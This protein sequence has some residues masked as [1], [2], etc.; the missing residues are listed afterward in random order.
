MIN[1]VNM[2]IAV[3]I[4]CYNE[5]LTVTKVVNDFKSNLPDADIY[6]YDNNS[7]DKTFELAKKAGAITRHESTQGKGSVVRSMFRD[8]DA[9]YYVL[10][11]GDDTYPAEEVHGLLELAINENVDMVIGDRLSNGTYSQENKRNFHGFGNNL[12]L[13]LVN[14]IF[15]SNVNDIMT[16][17]RVFSKKFVKNIPIQSQG[18]QIETEM[19]V[20]ALNYKF[21]VKEKQITYRDR[22]E[23][24]FS[25]L[26]TIK[27]GYRVLSILSSLFKHSKPVLFFG[28]IS[29]V[30]I[31]LSLIVGVPVILEFLSTH[32]ITLVPSAILAS[33]LAIVAFLF[34]IV[35][36][37]LDSMSYYNKL[38]FE[39]KVNQYILNESLKNKG[40]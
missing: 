4:P 11:D 15:K 26:N 27:D 19:T 8:I 30:F 21:K 3:L 13:F 29:F 36:L 25:K 23:G 5:E 38:D 6:V 22:P 12:V 2:K 1:E 10:V 9:D 18:F 20:F 7:T 28:L 24:S 31:L 39:H 35:S 32:Y 37:I 16:G 17:Y 14:W 40:E 34:F 33:G